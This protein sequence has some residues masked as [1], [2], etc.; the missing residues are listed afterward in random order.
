[1]KFLPLIFKNLRRRPVRTS[2]TFLAAMVSF[3][4]F[5]VLMILRFAF[6]FGAE[7]AGA[8]RL[9]MMN[10]MSMIQPLPLS[11]ADKIRAVPGVSLVT[12]S[13][14]FGGIYQDPST[15][16]FQF[17]VEPESYLAM[18]PEFKLPPEQMKAWLADRQG[19]IVGSAL[20]NRLGFKIGQ[21]I[22]IMATFN[23]P[24]SGGD[25]WEFN[26]V[27]IYDGA[28]DVDKTQFLFRHDYL[29]ENRIGGQGVTGWYM[30][31]VADPANAE[32]VARTVDAQFENSPFE[33]KT[34]TEGMMVQGWA[35]QV[36]NIGF[37]VSSIAAVVLFIIL[38][39]A[40]SQMS[41]A[42]RE[43]TNEIGAL[44]AIGFSD[45]LILMMV[46][47]ES[48]LIALLAGGTGLALAWMIGQAGDP[49]R[50]YMPIW[51]LRPF[52]VG[53]GFALAALVGLLAGA[54][55]AIAAMRLRISDALRR[56]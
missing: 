52:D 31:R 22:P 8:D 24:K 51:T 47:G 33:T 37:I 26:L 39:I 2:L 30:I 13:S 14:W 4:L 5:G 7:I 15:N 55:P 48:L 19:C 35:N 28:D 36:G 38:L 9:M 16:V 21:K 25:T 3:L 49:T 45:G 6:T 12:Y 20:A 27:G 44:K 50:G 56:S 32:N 23:R 29:T 34:Q 11:Y 40:A 17:A 10:K 18:Y 43:R 1:M 53:I 46:L 41:L 54:M 42:V